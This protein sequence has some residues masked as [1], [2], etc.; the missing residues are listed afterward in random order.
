MTE[1]QKE[2]LINIG[3]NEEDFQ[4]Y[5]FSEDGKLFTPLKDKVG[6]M[7]KTGEQV[8]NE[9]Y[10]NPPLPQQTKEYLLQKQLLETQAILAN[11]QEQILKQNGG[12]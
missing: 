11:L 9:D 4:N 10:L 8:Y 1:G 2:I 6:K 12:I 3:I 5:Y 7:I